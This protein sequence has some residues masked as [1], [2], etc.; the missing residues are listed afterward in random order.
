MSNRT[1]PRKG[2]EWAAEVRVVGLGG[3]RMWYFLC[4]CTVCV[5]TV[6]PAPGFGGERGVEEGTGV[7]EK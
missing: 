3:V 1:R 6:A 2:Q 5:F 4:G 7:F